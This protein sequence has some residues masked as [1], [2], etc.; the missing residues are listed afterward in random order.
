MGAAVLLDGKETGVVTNGELVVPAPAPPQVVLTFRKEGQ[1]E[2]KRIVKLPLAEGEGVSVTLL[3]AAATV[4]L[5][6]DP[7]GASVSL[8]GEKLTNADPHDLSIDPAT[9]HRLTV[10]LEGHVS[11]ESATPSRGR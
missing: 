7:P 10:A 4:F 8:D 3:A 9:E 5:R 2:E 6:T 1:R 11:Q